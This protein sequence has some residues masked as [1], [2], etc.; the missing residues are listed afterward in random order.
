LLL[1]GDPGGHRD[2]RQTWALNFGAAGMILRPLEL[3]LL[4][5]GI[6]RNPFPGHF[7]QVL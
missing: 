1:E 4:K 2:A 5:F 7:I 6:C 3:D